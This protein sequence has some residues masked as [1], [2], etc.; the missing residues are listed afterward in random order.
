M[1]KFRHRRQTREA[2]PAPQR[3]KLA[4]AAPARTASLRHLAPGAIGSGR[5]LTR[6]CCDLPT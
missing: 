5:W 2:S 3:A 6:T 1:S 4:E